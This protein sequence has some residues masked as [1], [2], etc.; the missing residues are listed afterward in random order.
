VIAFTVNGAYPKD[1]VNVKCCI[2]KQCTDTAGKDGVCLNDVTP[3]NKCYGV[4]VKGRCPGPNDVQ[5]CVFDAPTSSSGI[6][7]YF[8]V[9]FWIKS[10]IPL[11]FDDVTYPWPNYP[12]K[13]MLN[14]LP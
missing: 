6:G 7:A 3:I 11:N 8:D 4:F 14:G 13:T 5:C 10:F 9:S 1:S 12:G 2:T